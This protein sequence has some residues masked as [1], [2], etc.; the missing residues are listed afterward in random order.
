MEFIADMQ[1][2]AFRENPGNNGKVC[3]TG[4]WS[5]SRH[6]N[7]FGEIAHWFGVWTITYSVITASTS[8]VGYVGLI[9]P[10]LTMVILL[11]LSGM[12]TAE[13]VNQVRWFIAQGRRACIDNGNARLGSSCEG[14]GEA[15]TSAPPPLS[16]LASLVAGP[17]DEDA[18]VRVAPLY[19]R[20]L[21]MDR[22]FVP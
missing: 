8:F 17:V 9:S 1:K 16:V 22:P 12:P 3:N 11:F 10:L 20:R 15:F 19:F 4:L 2:N 14:V 6:P 5:V 7:F 21:E 18:G 13:G